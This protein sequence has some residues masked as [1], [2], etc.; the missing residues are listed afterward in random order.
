MIIDNNFYQSFIRKS[1]LMNSHRSCSM[2]M[3]RYCG[4]YIKLALPVASLIII[5]TFRYVQLIDANN[6]NYLCKEIFFIANMQD[7]S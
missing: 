5:M 3:N 1:S 7:D 6:P 2:S 4:Y